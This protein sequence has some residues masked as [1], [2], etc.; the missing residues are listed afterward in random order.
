MH[1]NIN[2]FLKE[3]T[4]CDMLPFNQKLVVLS[5]EMTIGQTIEAMVR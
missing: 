5:H 3:N 1:A 2:Q 4:I